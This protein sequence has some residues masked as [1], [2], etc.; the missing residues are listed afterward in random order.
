MYVVITEKIRS[1]SQFTKKITY[2]SRITKKINHFIDNTHL[3]IHTIDDVTTLVAF[4]APY[5]IIV[6]DEPW[7][8]KT[9]ES[10][11]PESNSNA[12]KQQQM[13][14]VALFS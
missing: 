10:L 4:P 13:V 2:I 8:F 7:W 14:M 11:M 6:V 12:Q 3:M 5:Y 9:A 1:Q